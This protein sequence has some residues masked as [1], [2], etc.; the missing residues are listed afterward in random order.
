MQFIAIAREKVSARLANGMP[1]SNVEMATWSRVGAC[2]QRET[3]P[4]SEDMKNQLLKFEKAIKLTIGELSSTKK[5]RSGRRRHKIEREISDAAATAYYVLTGKRPTRINSTDPGKLKR[6]GFVAFLSE[7]FEVMGV[8]ASL[9]NM[10]KQL[11]R[12]SPRGGSRSSGG[13]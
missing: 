8:E 6:T 1:A 4:T 10:S 13:N 3:T 2:H 11:A 5:S 9:D 12:R 7:L